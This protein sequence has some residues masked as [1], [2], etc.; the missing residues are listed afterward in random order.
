MKEKELFLTDAFYADA[1][2]TLDILNELIDKNQVADYEMYQNGTFLWMEV[3][4]N[5]ITKKILSPIISDFE[6]YKLYN[7]DNFSTDDET[8]IGLSPLQ[9]LHRNQFGNYKEIKW[10]EKKSRFLFWENL[11]DKF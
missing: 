1:N 11:P 2:L 4:E 6:A 8:E 10:D 9:T 7:A 3:F 5:E